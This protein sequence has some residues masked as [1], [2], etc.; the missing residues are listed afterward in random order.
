[1]LLNRASDAFV[2]SL[3]AIADGISLQ[4]GGFWT[5]CMIK[6]KLDASPVLE[7]TLSNLPV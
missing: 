5:V 6:G 1:M 3:A 7:T 4:L 2:G